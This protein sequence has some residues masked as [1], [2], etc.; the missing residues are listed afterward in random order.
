MGVKFLVAY[1]SV[2]NTDNELQILK[3]KK[4]AEEIVVI[5]TAVRIL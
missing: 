1:V 3:E 2:K 4:K 5:L